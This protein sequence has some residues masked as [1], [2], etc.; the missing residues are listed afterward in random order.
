MYLWRLIRN[1]IMRS[2]GPT[3]LRA[4][5]LVRKWSRIV[6][7][8][9]GFRVLL[10]RLL[11]LPSIWLMSMVSGCSHSSTSVRQPTYNY[12]S[13]DFAQVY[14]LLRKG[15][16]YPMNLAQLGLPFNSEMLS[17]GDSNLFVCPG[18]GSQPGPMSQIENWTDYI[19]V[20]N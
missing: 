16:I 3:P 9:R 12:M 5:V 19:Y 20:G 10:R 6:I 17:P 11:W 14:I 18:T 15:N 1:K 7:C 4:E 13:N 2:V 8:M